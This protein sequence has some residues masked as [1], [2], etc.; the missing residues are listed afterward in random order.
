MAS[1]Y[2]RAPLDVETGGLIVGHH[3]LLTLY[4]CVLSDEG[5]I[6][7]EL[8]MKLK[9]D[10]G[11][12]VVDQEALDVCGIN[13]EEHDKDPSTV[14]YSVGR[15]LFLEFCKRNMTGKR[16]LRPA[17]H[18]I[19][20]FDIPMIMA[21][22]RISQ[23]EWGEIFHY[24]HIDTMPI[25]T[26]LQDAGWLPDDL[27]GQESLVKYYGVTPRKAHVAKNDVHMWIDVYL[28][29]VRSLA[30]RKNGGAGTDELLILE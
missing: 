10:D 17:G 27:G 24:R 1:K 26:V 29:M 16:S 14:T 28:A 25:M 11:K 6:V 12:Y 19:A 5:Q 20:P 23:E 4:I 9:P 13:I 22:L 8:D 2:K 18:N 3:S 7:D 21:N 30:E 15:R